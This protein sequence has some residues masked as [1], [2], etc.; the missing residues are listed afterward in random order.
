MKGIDI[1]I[2]KL[3]NSIEN[4]ISGEIFTTSILLFKKRE[5]GFLA[6]KWVFNW[7]KELSYSDREVYKLVTEENPEIIQGLIS[8]EDKNDHIFMHLIENVFFNKGAGKLYA[9]VAGNLIAFACKRSYELGYE[10]IVSFISKTKL[11]H[12]YEKTLG[13]KQFKGNYLFI[14][15]PEA[16]SLI[17]RYF[18]HENKN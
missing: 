1:K 4:T 9:G 3:T 13:A 6:N 17:R 7:N 5:K 16:I 11:I 14:D 18:K 12:H 15:T 8:I 10:G 2:D